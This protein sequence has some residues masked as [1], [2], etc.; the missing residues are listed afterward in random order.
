MSKRSK[1]RTYK[2]IVR[3]LVNSGFTN[4]DAQDLVDAGVINDVAAVDRVTFGE[5]RDYTVEFDAHAEYPF[6]LTVDTRRA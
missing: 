5:W 6:K 1:Y 3:V 2:G 4:N